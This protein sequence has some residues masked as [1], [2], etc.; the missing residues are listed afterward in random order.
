MREVR[1]ERRGKKGK[2]REKEGGGKGKEREGREGK[3]EEKGDKCHTVLF[4]C[5]PLTMP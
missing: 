4:K 2:E 1:W 5:M 3:K